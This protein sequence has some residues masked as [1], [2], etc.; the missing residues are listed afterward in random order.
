LVVA[1]F[2]TVP[3]HELVGRKGDDSEA[4][5]PILLEQQVEILQNAGEC[6]RFS[7]QLLE[8]SYDWHRRVA[9]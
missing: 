2:Q 3:W 8:G 7:S 6:G 5:R 9:A 1:R 4:P